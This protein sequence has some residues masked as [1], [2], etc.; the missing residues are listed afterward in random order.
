MRSSSI[1]SQ[2]HGIRTTTFTLYACCADRID[3]SEFYQQTIFTSDASEPRVK[4][5][6]LQ[7]RIVGWHNPVKCACSE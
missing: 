1:C 3:T 6:L 7:R 2:V 5:G 4:V